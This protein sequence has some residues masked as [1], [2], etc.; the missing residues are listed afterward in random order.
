MARVW[1]SEGC[2]QF[3]VNS[4]NWIDYFQPIQRSHVMSP[5]LETETAGLYDV[6]C[7][8]KGGGMSGQA[9]A[10]RL[11]VSRALQAFSPNFRVP[12]KR[13]GLLRRDPRRVERKKPGQKKA[14]KKFQWV[15]R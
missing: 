10:V 14:R 6:W 4:K 5:F 8:V 12:L 1:V 11:G 15:K 2:G 13:A 9:G 3:T 7:T